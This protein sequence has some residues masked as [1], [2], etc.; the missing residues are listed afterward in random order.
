M[1]KKRNI[2]KLLVTGGAG[3]IGSAFIRKYLKSDIKILNIDALKYSG[4]L[5]NLR[6][7]KGKKNY[8][9]K[10]LDISK[11][12]LL[13]DEILSFD[14]DAMIH[15]AA[16]S[17]VDNSILKPSDFI[18]TNIIGTF[19]LLES[20][21]M[22]MNIKKKKNFLL[23]HVSTDEVFGS[24]KKSGKF[25][26]STKYDPRSP[27]S[28][29]KAASDHLVRAWSHTYKIPAI[30]TN[31]SNNYGPYQHNEKLIPTIITNGINK[32]NIPIYG[33]GKNIRDWLH[34]DDHINALHKILFF[35]EPGERFNIGGNNEISNI[36]LVRI[37]C[38]ILN[39]KINDNFDRSS[40]IKFVEDRKGHDYRYAIDSSFIKKQLM[41]Q[42]K[43]PF[44]SGLSETVNWYLNNR[45]NI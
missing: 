17:H 41:W 10:K 8:F 42:P 22:I 24:L 9:F 34:V 28:S 20:I 14:P 23:V 27:Y 7:T 43:I 44:K 18:Q 30:I 32:K 25:R 13:S 29:S 35:G 36:N 45:K 11:F 38:D 21:R 39:K 16:E 1:R 31:C 26:E 19:N 33:D 12:K 2:K 3:F 4:N 5:E 40:L 37:I 6:E 15:F